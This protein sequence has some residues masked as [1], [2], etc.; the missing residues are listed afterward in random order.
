[1]APCKM[2]AGVTVIF[3]DREAGRGHY[4]S[5]SYPSTITQALKNSYVGFVCISTGTNS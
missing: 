4:E 5:V 2:E 1:M 3:I